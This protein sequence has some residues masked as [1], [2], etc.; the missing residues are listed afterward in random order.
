MNI[1]AYNAA[2]QVLSK[3]LPE[4]ISSELAI[5]CE[6]VSYIYTDAHWADAGD[7]IIHQT[8]HA[9]SCEFKA[10]QITKLLRDNPSANVLKKNHGRF[11]NNSTLNMNVK[12]WLIDTIWSQNSEAL[13]KEQIISVLELVCKIGDGASAENHKKQNEQAAQSFGCTVDQLTVLKQKGNIKSPYGHIACEVAKL[14]TRNSKKTINLE[15][16]PNGLYFLKIEYNNSIK[17]MKIIKN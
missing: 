7:T 11:K 16:F 3:W 15:R 2:Y 8:K 10:K 1:F 9:R 13:T 14:I 5:L 12:D 4:L 6:E 17:L